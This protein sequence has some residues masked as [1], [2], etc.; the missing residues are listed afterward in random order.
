MGLRL[1]DLRFFEVCGLFRLTRRRCIGDVEGGEIG[2]QHGCGLD[3]LWLGG[4]DGSRVLWYHQLQILLE[5]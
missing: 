2:W 5:L 3:G 1:L 4:E